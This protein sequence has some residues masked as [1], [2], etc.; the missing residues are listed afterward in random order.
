MTRDLTFD[1]RYDDEYVHEYYGDGAK[2]AQQMREIYHDQN[3]EFPDAFDSTMTVPP[4][5]FIQVTAQDDV[6]VDGLRN[7]HVPPGLNVEILDFSM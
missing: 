4:V 3:L 6:D 2:L 1:V 5:H 7:I